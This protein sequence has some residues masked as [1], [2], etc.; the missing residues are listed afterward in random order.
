MKEKIKNMNEVYKQIENIDTRMKSINKQLD[1][2]KK[3]NQIL[4]LNIQEIIE[5]QKLT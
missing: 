5:K 4:I 2:I 3:I 1:H